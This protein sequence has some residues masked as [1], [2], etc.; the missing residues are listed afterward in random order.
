MFLNDVSRLMPQFRQVLIKQS[1]MFVSTFFCA[2]IE[3]LSFGVKYRQ[4]GIRSLDASGRT[5]PSDSRVLS[6]KIHR[7]ALHDCYS[8]NSPPCNKMS[9]TLRM[10]RLTVFDKELIS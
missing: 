5:A 1:P 8:Q 10:S 2:V 4:F 6:Q 9:G 3:S 7:S